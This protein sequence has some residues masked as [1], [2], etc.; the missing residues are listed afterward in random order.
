MANLV[1]NKN[2]YFKY[3]EKLLV[4]MCTLVFP[5]QS[6]THI[7][8]LIKKRKNILI[9]KT[10]YRGKKRIESFV[11]LNFFFLNKNVILYS[12]L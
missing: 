11:H 6:L 12:T 5:Y 3:T 2:I 9:Q 10:Q 1:L 8:L 4:K 7:I